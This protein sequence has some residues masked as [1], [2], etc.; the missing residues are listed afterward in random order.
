[1]SQERWYLE[2]SLAEYTIDNQSKEVL[3]K[4][5]EKITREECVALGANIFAA[6]RIA[7]GCSGSDEG[8]MCIGTD[9]FALFPF[10][11]LGEN[12]EKN[13]LAVMFT[14]RDDG[15]ILLSDSASGFYLVDENGFKHR[16]P[17]SADLKH[18]PGSR[19]DTYEVLTLEQL[20]SIGI[21]PI[22]LDF[23]RAGDDQDRLHEEIRKIV[24]GAKSR[25]EVLT[26]LAGAI[27]LPAPGEVYAVQGNEDGFDI[28][29]LIGKGKHP[30][31]V[32][33]VEVGFSDFFSYV[34]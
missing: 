34:D 32:H 30:R 14:Y 6:E 27:I 25:E 31:T 29:F 33:C 17:I 23:S 22:I 24:R 19:V 4:I 7:K 3:K 12:E 9:V 21:E 15:T 2:K 16:Y 10:V 1:M 11:I 20:Q 26:K 8:D 5:T 13:Y 28:L 18:L